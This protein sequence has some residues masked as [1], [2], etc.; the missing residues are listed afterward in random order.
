MELRNDSQS[1]AALNACIDRYYRS[2][3]LPCLPIGE[4]KI[5]TSEINGAI[6]ENDY[7]QNYF[8][9]RKYFIKYSIPIDTRNFYA[10]LS[11]G[12]GPGYVPMKWLVSEENESKFSMES[13]TE[14]VVHNLKMLDEYLAGRLT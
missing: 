2:K 5:N 4:V 9:A 11:L 8:V 12:V 14:A 3:G 1:Y 10:M 7:E 13:T 6:Y